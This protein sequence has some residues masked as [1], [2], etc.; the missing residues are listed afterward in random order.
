MIKSLLFRICVSFEQARNTNT[1]INL[2]YLKTKLSFW[3]FSSSKCIYHFQ[4]T[5]IFFSSILTVPI[6]R[7]WLCF[8]TEN[9]VGG[10]VEI[11]RH[12]DEFLYQ[13][14]ILRFHDCRVCFK[15]SMYSNDF[16]SYVTIFIHTFF[17]NEVQSSERNLPQHFLCLNYQYLST[18]H[19]WLE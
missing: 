11:L 15:F 7:C 10:R 17:N 8:L 14:T 6:Q 16:P 4:Q 18:I 5:M 2:L 9:G 13:P 3:L 1:Y 12:F 19:P